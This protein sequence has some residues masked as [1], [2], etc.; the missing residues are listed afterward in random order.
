MAK[1]W[2][3]Y[4]VRKTVIRRVHGRPIC[5]VLLRRDKRILL[6]CHTKHYSYQTLVP[7]SREKFA[8]SWMLDERT[9]CGT[10]AVILRRESLTRLRLWNVDRLM[11]V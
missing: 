4:L 1:D 3:V 2:R 9:V 11:F 10:T 5:G 8:A 7:T 6:G